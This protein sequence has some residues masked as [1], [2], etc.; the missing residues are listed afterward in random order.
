MNFLY[1]I[2]NDLFIYLLRRLKR[3]WTKMEPPL[4]WRSNYFMSKA[5]LMGR[6]AAPGTERPLFHSCVWHFAEQSSDWSHLA[7]MTGLAVAVISW[8]RRKFDPWCHKNQ[9]ELEF[10]LASELSAS[11]NWVQ[12]LS[13]DLPCIWRALIPKI[14]KINNHSSLNYCFIKV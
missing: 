4:S 12:A 13:V 6:K 14:D 10:L 11:Q 3:S 2:L 5:C 7:E 9:W 8:I 1:A